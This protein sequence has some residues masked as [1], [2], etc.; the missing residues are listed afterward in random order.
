MGD[1]SE[2]L[3]NSV[4]AIN[5]ILLAS[6]P[7]VLVAAI[8]GVLISLVQALTQVQEQTLAFGFK[9]IAVILTLFA[10]MESIGNNLLSFTRHVFDKAATWTF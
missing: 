4:Q 1:F 8:V 3:S 7:P 5:L 6:L 9:L 10:T 2:M